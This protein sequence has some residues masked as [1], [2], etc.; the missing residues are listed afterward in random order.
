MSTATNRPT[1]QHAAATQTQERQP[2][3]LDQTIEETLKQKVQRVEQALSTRAEEIDRLLPSYM[4]GQA[5]RLIARAKQY[6]ARG[7][8]LLHKCSEAS[9]I[10]CVLEAAELGFAI[11]GKMVHAVPYN[12]KVKDSNGNEVRTPDGRTLWG[13]EA[14]LIPDYKGLIAAAKRCKTIRDCWARIIYD[15]DTF[16]YEE[17]DG[18]V[19]YRHIPDLTR[20]RDSLEG[21]ICILAVATHP[22]GWFRTELMP[23]SDVLHIRA[24]SKSYKDA[25]SMTPW[26]T[27]PGEMGKKTVLRRL[28]KTF[29]DDPGLV[30]LMELDDRDYEDVKS[31]SPASIAHNSPT[32]MADALAASLQARTESTPPAETPQPQ[33]PESPPEEQ[34]PRDTPKPIQTPPEAEKTANASPPAPK[35]NGGRKTSSPEE[36]RQYVLG[37]IE[38]ARNAPNVADGESLLAK[39]RAGLPKLKISDAIRHELELALD[40]ADNALAMAGTFSQ[41]APPDQDIY[42]PALEALLRECSTPERLD[43]IAQR[44]SEDEGSVSAETYQRGTEMI[45]LVRGRLGA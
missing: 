28:L 43:E 45:G 25:K 41:D 6:F 12:C 37:K 11:D 24:R 18:Q 38:E 8:T 35:P 10:K 1:G 4:K 19:R 22:D 33:E 14:Q 21:A 20:D 17:Q 32:S 9:F 15:S 13:Y 40:N 30:R 23:T 31:E 44:W 27:D 16:E 36:T 39:I 7:G 42:I 5:S 29:N 2:S 26:N 34:P 3:A